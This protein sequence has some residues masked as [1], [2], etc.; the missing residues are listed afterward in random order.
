M[1]RSLGESSF[2][3]LRD[4]AHGLEALPVL[5]TVHHNI[6]RPHASRANGARRRQHPRR[7]TPSALSPLTSEPNRAPSW[8]S[9][10]LDRQVWSVKTCARHDDTAP[11]PDQ[12]QTARLATMAAPSRSRSQIPPG[13]DC[14]ALADLLDYAGNRRLRT[15]NT[16]QCNAAA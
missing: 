9:R 15:T 3:L 4:C 12:R 7:R 1:T 14:R 16:R 2:L 11:S 13:H 5:A 8:R 10:E 6:H